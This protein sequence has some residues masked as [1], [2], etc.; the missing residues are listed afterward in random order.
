MVRSCS[1]TAVKKWGIG[2]GIDFASGGISIF[3]GLQK[4][5]D[6]IETTGEFDTASTIVGKRGV[7]FNTEKVVTTDEDGNEVVRHVASGGNNVNIVGSDVA[8]GGDAAIAATRDVNVI[9]GAEAQSA[10]RTVKKSGFGL[11]LDLGSGGISAFAGLRKTEDRF[12]LDAEYT[13]RS[14]VRPGRRW[15]QRETRPILLCWATSFQT[16]PGFSRSRGAP[17]RCPGK[18]S[19]LQSPITPSPFR[20]RSRDLPRL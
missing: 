11:S 14:S 10:E 4:T 15:M 16:C 6:E 12:D 7:S 9:A 8:A 2:V 13:A 17:C 19:Q 18:I 5:K 1:T 20:L 3:G